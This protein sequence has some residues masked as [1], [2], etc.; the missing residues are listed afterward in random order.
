M[1]LEILIVDNRWKCLNL[2]LMT[3]VVLN[4]ILIHQGLNK[5]NYELSILAC[6]DNEIIKLNNKFLKKN[7]STNVISWPSR[8][9]FNFI[10]NIAER[11]FLGDIA[12]SFDKCAEEA[13]RFKKTFYNHVI[14][15][16]IHSIL[17]L[18]GFNHDTKENSL[19]MEDLEIKILKK[20]KINNPYELE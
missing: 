10:E 17:H 9:N 13:I 19:I 14:H 12:I 4:K 5:K 11:V 2:T 1:S 20:L 18:L 16:L 8:E 7:L 6:S 3:K 15:L